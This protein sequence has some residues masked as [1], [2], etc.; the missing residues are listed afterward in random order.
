MGLRHY[1]PAFPQ[2]PGIEL[3]DHCLDSL[4]DLQ[5]V[6]AVFLFDTKANGGVAVLGGDQYLLTPG[7]LD[8]GDIAQ[9]DRASAPPFRPFPPCLERRMTPP[10]LIPAGILT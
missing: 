4:Q 3:L 9:L 1:Q 6:G 7:H 10:S 2:F 5:R 8:V